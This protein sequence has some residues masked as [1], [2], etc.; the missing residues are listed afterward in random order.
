MPDGTWRIIDLD[1]VVRFLESIGAK[2][3]STAY[4]PPEAT[5][6]AKNTKRVL[7]RVPD[8]VDPEEVLVAHPT[9]DIWSLG[10]ISFMALARRSL[11]ESD[12]R[13]RLKDN[14]ECLRLANWGPETLGVA[15]AEA[16][17]EMRNDGVSDMKVQLPK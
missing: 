4:A 11:F 5:L 16:D 9:F 6:V 2:D 8:S 15:I 17:R 12:N 14:A 13:D 3:L 10:V 1:A 7:F